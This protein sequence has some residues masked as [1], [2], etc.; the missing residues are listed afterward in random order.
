MA[1][2]GMDYGGDYGR[3]DA[4]RGG[5]GWREQQLG[6]MRSDGWGSDWERFPGEEGWYGGPRGYDEHFR[7]GSDGPGRQGGMRGGAQ[8]FEGRSFSGGGYGGRDMGYGGGGYGSQGWDE[9]NRGGGYGSQGWDEGNR[10]GGQQRSSMRASELMTEK[11]EVVTPDATLADVARRMRDMDVGII[12]VVD[13]EENRRLKGVIT[14]RDIA[15]RA[16]AEGKDG[17]AKVSECMT[18]DVEAVN[19]NDMMEK[20]IE[21]MKREQVRRVPVTDREG[22]LVG[23]IAQ[24]DLA[25]DFAE[26]SHRRQ[27]KVVDMLERVSESSSGGSRSG[28]RSRSGGS[29]RMAAGSRQRDESGG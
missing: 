15:I 12:P 11:P 26:T 21:V 28:N 25:T 3:F 14:D 18:T 6:G 27:H 4:M 20:V 16:V 17:K 1:R 24:A 23:I 13:S 2:Y 19:K 9:G 8:D 29:N 5:G 22:R 10:G 7:G